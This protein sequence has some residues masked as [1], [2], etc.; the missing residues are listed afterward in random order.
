[1]RV[2]VDR[3]NHGKDTEK[4]IL[5]RNP[6]SYG[7]ISLEEAK[8]T[9][10]R[11][12][13]KSCIAGAISFSGAYPVIDSRKCIFCKGCI[14]AC[15]AA[16]LKMDGSC[17]LAEV[18]ELGE[19]LRRKVYGKFKRSLTLR[20]VDTG[21]CNACMLELAATQNTYYDLSRF[22]ISFAASPRHSDGIVVTGPV[23]INMREALLKT[24]YAMPEPRLVIALG[25]CAHDGGLFKA[26]HGCCEQLDRLLPVDLTIPGC[27]PSP[28]AI[29]YGFLK[30]MDRI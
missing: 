13:E 16:A 27:P 23:T 8:C 12:C 7:S 1:M 5:T 19:E 14:D 10:C 20:S 9:G 18:A 24:Y 11:E 3:Q 25:A 21:S 29:I 15:K 22:G 6:H 2:L 28:Q 17:M 26:A 4:D 30:L